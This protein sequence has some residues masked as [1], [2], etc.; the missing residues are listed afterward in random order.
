ML[1]VSIHR[2]R[3]NLCIVKPKAQVAVPSTDATAAA[4]STD[5]A[6]APTD[7]Q[8][9]VSTTLST[10]TSVTSSGTTPVEST[11]SAEPTPAPTSATSAETAPTAFGASFLTGDAL[12]TTIN[13]MVEMGFPR[14]QVLRA[15]RASFNN[16]DRAVEY[17][18]TVCFYLCR[19]DLSQ[20]AA[21]QGIPSFEAEP[22]AP[23]PAAPPVPATPAPAPQPANQPQNLFQVSPK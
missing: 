23:A 16:P 18:M 8:P 9:S 1:F 3:L 14:D 5:T 19:L 15:L 4:A 11:V 13:N 21:G 17:L 2:H 10:T 20:S 22:T 6:A 12:Q 7:A